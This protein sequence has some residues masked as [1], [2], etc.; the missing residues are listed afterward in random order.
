MPP[1]PQAADFA[2]EAGEAFTIVDATEL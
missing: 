1:P 2:P